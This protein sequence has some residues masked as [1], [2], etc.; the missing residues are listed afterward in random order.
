V[1]I[2]IVS[3]YYKPEAVPIP[4]QLAGALA[5]RG[6]H[7]RV[8]TG[9]PNYPSGRL[10][11]GYRQKLRHTEFDGPVKVRRVP[12][13][14]SHST[15]VLGRIASYLSFGLSCLTAGRHIRGADVVYV[16]ATP[17]TA[18]IAPSVWRI[19]HRI[20]F[21]LHV[22]Y[23]WPVSITGSNMVRAGRLSRLI[24]NCLTPWLRRLYQSASATV[25]IAPR[26]QATLVERGAPV[27][28]CHTVYN[29]G[30]EPAGAS[31][32]VDRRNAR[33]RDAFC[34][35]YAG[36]VGDLQDLDT[37]IRAA[38]AA[39]DLSGFVLLIYGSGVALPR[40]RNL[41]GELGATNVQFRDRVSGEELEAMY[42]E[43][44]FQVVS[45]KD[46]PI[47]HGTIPS[48]FPASL[49]FG[50]PVIT[51]VR[52]DVASIVEDE[53][54]GYTAIPESAESLEA[55]F[56]EAYALPA[57]RWNSMAERAVTYYRQTMS[58]SHGI[59]KLER[60]LASASARNAKEKQL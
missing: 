41:V 27:D 57:D 43:S 36:N 58:I 17:M 55:A 46:L 28:R 7:V 25:A 60:I 49:A 5:D 3:Q 13:I 15:S 32:D 6:H 31:S 23:I 59:G 34:V 30:N 18:A 38:H 21:V 26:M 10:F 54:L 19:A 40:L 11:S 37:V 4:A 50:V 52:G 33:A 45:L 8:V 12:L 14:L 56:R 24:S 53:G 16:Y 44:A 9:Y 22:Q 35:T 1:K 2:V 20:P 51:T 39:R 29:W 48:K 42:R 47:F